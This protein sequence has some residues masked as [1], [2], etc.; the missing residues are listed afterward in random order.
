MNERDEGAG[1][2]ALIRRLGRLTK[3]GRVMASDE[4]DFEERERD[5][6][7]EREADGRDRDRELWHYPEGWTAGDPDD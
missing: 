2:R 6:Q 5:R 3:D 1:L 7:Y 4:T